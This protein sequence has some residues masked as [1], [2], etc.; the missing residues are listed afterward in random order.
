MGRNRD[1]GC[2]QSDELQPRVFERCKV[3]EDFL[4]TP[5]PSLYAAP[6]TGSSISPSRDALSHTRRKCLVSR[7]FGLQCFVQG[8]LR[9]FVSR[10]ASTSVLVPG[11]IGLQCWVP[12]SPPVLGPKRVL[13]HSLLS[14]TPPP[15]HPSA[16]SAPSA[17]L[18]RR[19]TPSHHALRS[20]RVELGPHTEWCRGSRV[21]R[22]VVHCRRQVPGQ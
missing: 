11:G 16:H 12:G 21:C 1:L 7:V 14:P 9:C 6:V 18:V 3:T 20:Q 8:C 22:A 10:G 2:E 5:Q 17:P 15:T 4:H 13:A 19:A